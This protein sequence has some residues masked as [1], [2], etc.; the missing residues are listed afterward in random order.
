M[1]ISDLIPMLS[2]MMREVGNAEICVQVGK[3]DPQSID[4]V[5]TALNFSL[6]GIEEKMNLAVLKVLPPE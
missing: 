6:P 4:S 2:S 5:F 1:K 3:G